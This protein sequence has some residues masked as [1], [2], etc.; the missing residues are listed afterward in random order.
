MVFPFAVGGICCASYTAHPVKFC[1]D[2]GSRRPV[3]NPRT[4]T[5]GSLRFKQNGDMIGQLTYPRIWQM[6][7]NAFSHLVP[8]CA[9]LF[10]A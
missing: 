6:S 5:D 9:I 2:D 4:I 10:R 7:N 8:P 1:I 3:H